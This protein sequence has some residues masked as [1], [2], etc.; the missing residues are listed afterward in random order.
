[1]HSRSNLPASESDFRSEN[2]GISVVHSPRDLIGEHGLF[3]KSAKHPLREPRYE[4]LQHGTVTEKF[5]SLDP[6]DR[7]EKGS[8]I[9]FGQ[10]YRVL[11]VSRDRHWM[12]I[13]VGG[14]DTEG[15][16]EVHHHTACS[17]AEFEHLSRRPQPMLTSRT[18]LLE[19]RDHGERQVPILLGASLPRLD[20]CGEIEVGG[21]RFKLVEGESAPTWLEPRIG[22][23][24]TIL[25]ETL[26]APYEWGGK[27]GAYDCSGLVSVAFSFFGVKLPH[28]ARAQST[29][30]EGLQSVGD[31]KTGDVIAYGDEADPTS[32]KH[33][34]IALVDGEKRK[35]LHASQRV[36][37]NP[38]DS[39]GQYHR[40][41]NRVV[42]ALR[43]LIDFTS[44]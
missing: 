26:G 16:I 2:I 33:I 34:G 44:S 7:W 24:L 8:E 5:E 40:P 4:I 13:K 11:E 35:I 19:S 15:W 38:L 6:S 18:G 41:L 21:E 30:G 23:L 9:L 36:R 31:L 42:R 12:K 10:C 43:R 17:G 29:R 25:R 32:V 28:S 3:Q 1:M 20:R 27:G 39:D 37:V 22:N 14:Y